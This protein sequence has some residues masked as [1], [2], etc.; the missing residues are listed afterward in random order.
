MT[1]SLC[2]P[3]DLARDALTVRQ[4]A[5]LKVLLAE[6]MAGNPF[7]QERF[8]SS[9]LSRDEVLAI[10]SLAALQRLPLTS[11]AD[12]AVDQAAHPPYGTNLTAASAAYTRL[13]QTSGTTTGQPMRWLDTPQSWQWFM[14]CWEQNF[15]IMGLR[16]EDRFC[17]PFSFGPFIGFWAAFESATRHGHF[18][19]AGGGMTSEARLRLMLDNR[20]TIVCCTPTYALRLAETAERDGVDLRSSSVRLLL[21]A[22]EP[23]GS[24]SSL[25]QR[26]EEQWGARVLD[27]WGMT[28]LG[29]LGIECEASPGGLHVLETEAIAEIVDPA[30][31]EPVIPD[32]AGIQRG[33]L[34]MTN[35]GRI[36]SPVIRYRTGD[37][38]EAESVS[39]AC[40]RS[41]VRLRGGI[42]GRADDMLIIRGNNVFPASVEALLREFPEIVEYRI[43]IRTVRSMHQM[44]IEIEPGATLDDEPGEALRERVTHAIKDRFNFV[45]DVLLAGCGL[46]PRFELKGRRIVREDDRLS[47][48]GNG[49]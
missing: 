42:L 10:D 15:R 49:S 5:K 22:G 21:V 14:D 35:L 11:K 29:A 47:A 46:L 37:L 6:V 38:V 1:D 30:T 26:L 44:R 8:R 45:P 27:H 40:G 32:A 48:A 25:R 2:Q 13:H 19:V 3:E 18:C 9:G 23:G 28:E 16:P 7:W 36:G 4:M 31:G 41:L 39:C 43:T 24:V 33:E 20:A 12:L 34:V 17:F